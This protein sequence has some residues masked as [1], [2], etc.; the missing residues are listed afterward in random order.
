MILAL[1]PSLC[2]TGWVLAATKD[3][4]VSELLC[5]ISLTF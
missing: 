4:T 5:G 1:D 2:A 3:A